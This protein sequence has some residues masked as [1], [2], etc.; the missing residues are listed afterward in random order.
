MKRFDDDDVNIQKINIDK[1]TWKLDEKVTASHITGQ[2]PS[3]QKVKRKRRK[4]DTSDSSDD[5]DS[6]NELD[7]SY[8]KKRSSKSVPR[9]QGNESID[10]MEISSNA[11][12]TVEN[13]LG[14][15]YKSHSKLDSSPAALSKL[16]CIQSKDSCT[17]KSKIDSEDKL[18][19]DD[20]DN[21]SNVSRS[22]CDTDEIVRRSRGKLN[23]KGQSDV[24]SLQPLASFK[25]LDTSKQDLQMKSGDD[26]TT[27]LVLSEFDDGLS[28]S[29]DEEKESVDAGDAREDVFDLISNGKIDELLQEMFKKNSQHFM[30]KASLDK[31][32]NISVDIDKDFVSTKSLQTKK[33]KRV[34]TESLAKK[35]QR[36]D[37][38][39]VTQASAI[40]S[41][42]KTESKVLKKRKR[43]QVEEEDQMNRHDI[44]KCQSENVS[45]LLETSLDVGTPKKRKKILPGEENGKQGSKKS[46]KQDLENNLL[47]SSCISEVKSDGSRSLTKQEMSLKRTSAGESTEYLVGCFPIGFLLIH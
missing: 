39:E 5:T 43:S 38:N 15:K 13:V 19:N 7:S 26:V 40:A 32:A 9:K 29:S 46:I 6:D 18:N 30:E 33:R 11:K 37:M 44:A 8:D 24:Q 41:A 47:T 2:K 21:D 12:E 20:S 23:S 10:S 28:S 22:S 3:K 45:S 16:H 31:A 27:R 35:K 25:I 36:I 14:R 42:D 34:E 4:S 1:L 17:L